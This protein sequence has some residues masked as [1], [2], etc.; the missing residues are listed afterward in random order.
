MFN[1]LQFELLATQAALDA[2][3]ELPDAATADAAIRVLKGRLTRLEARRG[4]V[5]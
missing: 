2:E 5:S 1:E 3:C 4:Q